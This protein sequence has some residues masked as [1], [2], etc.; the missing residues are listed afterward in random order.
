MVDTV[1]FL[2]LHMISNQFAFVRTVYVSFVYS[3]TS[4]NLEFGKILSANESETMKAE[5]VKV[6]S[7]MQGLN[8]Q[9]NTL[10]GA[11]EELANMVMECD[12]D[13]TMQSGDELDNTIVISDDEDITGEVIKTQ[14]AE[15]Q[16]IKTGVE[17][18][19]GRR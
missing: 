9:V 7:N 2:I 11:M 16:C 14:T 5:R 10:R 19:R 6:E 4:Q 13:V 15:S 8:V 17:Q 12:D 1:P 3:L 18:M